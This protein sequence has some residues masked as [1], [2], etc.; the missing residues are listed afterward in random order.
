MS[1]M[2]KAAK[3]RSRAAGGTCPAWCVFDH[4]RNGPPAIVLHESLPAVTEISGPRDADVPEWIDVRTT[5]YSPEESGE[6]PRPPAVELSCHQGSRYRVTTLTADEAR[7]L[8][9][10]LSAAAAQV[11][12]DPHPPGYLRHDHG[13]RVISTTAVARASARPRS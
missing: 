5:Q 4:D 2:E 10:S 8:A 3:R 1:F 11:D 13:K 12:G 6:P 7:R 9:A